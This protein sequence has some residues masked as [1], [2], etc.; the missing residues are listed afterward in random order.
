MKPKLSC[1]KQDKELI[2][3]R[4]EIDSVDQEIVKLFRKRFSIVSKVKKFKQKN[5]LPMTDKKREVEI[6]DKLGKKFDIKFVK[7]LY[8]VVFRY[9][10]KLHP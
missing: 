10:K 9:G 8:M 1:K 2:E 5:N 3:F 4:K 7:D 6:V